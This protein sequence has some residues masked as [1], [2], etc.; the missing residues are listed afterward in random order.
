MQLAIN[1]QR[2]IS[3]KESI[4]IDTEG[5]FVTTRLNEIARYYLP[6]LAASKVLEF[7]HYCR[8]HDIVELIS[9]LHRL[10]SLITK[11]LEVNY[12]FLLLLGKIEWN[13]FLIF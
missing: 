5:G 1:Q 11:H 7:I 12:L 8:C 13:F 10:D 6:E 4:Y 2:I 3:K 9:I